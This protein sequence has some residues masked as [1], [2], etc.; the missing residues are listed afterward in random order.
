MFLFSATFYPIE[1]YP[2]ALQIVVRLTPLYQGVD[3][4]RSLT[5]GAI[6]PILLVHVAYLSVMGL[7]R[8]GGHVAAARQAPAQVA[9]TVATG[10]AG[11][12]DRARSSRAG[13]ARGWS[14]GAS[15]SPARRSPGSATR[16]TGAG[17]CPGSATRMR[18]S[19]CSGWRRR[20]T[21]A[22]GPAG[23]SPAMRRAT[24]C[25]RG[26]S[27]AGL[28]DRPVSRR[29]DDGLTLT[30]AYIAAAVRCAPPAN[31]PTTEERDTCAPFLVREIA[32]LDGGAGARGA[33]RVRLG[34]GAAG[35]RGAGPRRPAA[36][37]VRARRR[38]A[39]RA[40]HAPRLVPPEPA[41]HV[42][43]PPDRSAMFEAVLARARAIVRSESQPAD[44]RR[45]RARRDDVTR[46]DA[47]SM[48]IAHA[49]GRGRMRCRA[50]RCVITR[51][52]EACSCA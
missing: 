28:A 8:A 48:P 40:V 52:P 2:P 27:R 21:A 41:E 23:S 26:A 12:A 47:A 29:A 4:I 36:T 20:P 33:R 22:T 42:H 38:G 19:C 1:T 18:G 16:R 14:S 24:S 46:A 37:A 15:G 11:R 44:R 7:D 5:V 6:S 30:D 9:R 25:G 49:G 43:R 13:A 10:G 45:R 32:L 35:A 3:L 31:K 51:P 17:R 50:D 34:R 39:R